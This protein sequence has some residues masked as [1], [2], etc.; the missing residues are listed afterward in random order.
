MIIQNL[1]WWGKSCVLFV[2]V[3]RAEWSYITEVASVFNKSCASR[4]LEGAHGP[5][6]KAALPQSAFYI[7][8]TDA[9]LESHVGSDFNAIDDVQGH[10]QGTQ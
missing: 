2:Q 6:A 5:F 3:T 1:N 9:H 8:V 4:M 10:R 7:I